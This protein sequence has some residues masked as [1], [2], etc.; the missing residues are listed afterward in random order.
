MN[1]ECN[2]RMRQLQ[3]LE[4]WRQLQLETAQARHAEQAAHAEQQRALLD[5]CKQQCLATQELLRSQLRT[6]QPLVPDVLLSQFVSLQVE[7]QRRHE[8]AFQSAQAAADAAQ[9]CVRECFEQL[10]VVQKLA[11]RRHEQLHQ[12]QQRYQQRVLDE[13]AAGR[14]VPRG[15]TTQL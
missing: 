3:A 11:A 15:G 4:R 5:D 13:Q 9:R 12:A 1:P 10:S 14:P 6:A 8:M 2:T 7:A